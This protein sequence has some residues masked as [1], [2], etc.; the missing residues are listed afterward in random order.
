MVRSTH[1][2]WPQ[3]SGETPHI[4]IV[5]TDP[6]YEANPGHAGTGAVVAAVC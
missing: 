3:I 2:I 4:V 1:V 5:Q 6:G